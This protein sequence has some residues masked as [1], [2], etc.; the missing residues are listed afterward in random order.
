[1]RQVMDRRRIITR[2]RSE[3]WRRSSAE[4]GMGSKECKGH[5]LNEGGLLCVRKLPCKAVSN[6]VEF[7]VQISK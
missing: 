4:T 7:P 5:F 2:W 1:M 6:N 3:F